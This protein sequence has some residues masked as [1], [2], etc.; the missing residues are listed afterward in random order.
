MTFDGLL[1]FVAK[2]Q[3]LVR[4]VFTGDEAGAFG[5]RLQRKLTAMSVT[6]D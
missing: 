1:R 2:Q 5:C 3:R 4:E 6:N